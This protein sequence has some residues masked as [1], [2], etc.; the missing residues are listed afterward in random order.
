M[1]EILNRP[2]APPAPNPPKWM[3]A[4]SNRE[5]A[6]EKATLLTVGQPVQ[7]LLHAAR[8]IEKYLNEKVPE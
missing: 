4:R 2:V 5:I 3:A 7:N 6:L 8:E 1:F